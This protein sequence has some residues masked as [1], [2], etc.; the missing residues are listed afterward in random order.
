V[1]SVKRS[2]GDVEE[3]LGHA[4]FREVRGEGFVEFDHR[5]ILL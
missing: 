1:R 3:G 5:D 4:P 2:G